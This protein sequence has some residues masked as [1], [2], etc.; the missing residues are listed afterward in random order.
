MTVIGA[1]N[2]CA[3]IFNGGQVFEL[4][5]KH[6]NDHKKNYV[7]LIHYNVKGIEIGSHLVAS[8]LFLNVVVF[9][10]VVLM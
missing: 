2:H 6:Q 5:Q 8:F 9:F 3:T 1:G 4:L 7:V 10:K